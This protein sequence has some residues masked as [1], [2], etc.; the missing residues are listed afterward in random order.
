[1]SEIPTEIVLAIGGSVELSILAKATSILVLALV[2]LRMLRRVSASV[3]S[4]IL[5]STFGALMILPIAAV[6]LPPVALDVGAVSVRPEPPSLSAAVGSAPTRH[7]GTAA[8]N[9]FANSTVDRTRVPVRLLLI[10]GWVS[11]ALVFLVPAIETLGHLRRL[12]R[13]SRPWLNRDTLVRNL[14]REAGPSRHVELLV[15]DD[16]AVPFTYGLMRPAIMMPADAQDWTDAEVRRALVHELEHVRRRDWPVHVMARLVCAL[17]WFHPLV[18]IAWRRFCLE[19][20]RACDDAVVRSA[21]GIAY[22]EQLV[23]LARMVSKRGSAPVLSMA[24]RGDLKTRVAAVLDAKQTRGRVGALSG[25]LTAG[26]A[27]TLAI[28]ISPLKA[29]PAAGAGAVGQA[30]EQHDATVSFVQASVV[31]H[32]TGK[33][34]GIPP[35]ING[36][37]TAGGMTLKDLIRI[38]YGPSFPLLTSQIVG[39]PAWI[40]TDRFDIDAQVPSDMT[41]GASWHP[42]VKA[43]LQRLLGERFKLQL[44]R[45]TRESPS[46]D[47]VLANT[48]RQLGPGL[49]PSAADCVDLLTS[50]SPPLE[51]F[52]ERACG[53]NQ[54]APG[55]LAG[56]KLTMTQLA[57]VFS[58]LGKLNRVVRDRTG[59][60]GAFDVHLEYTPDSLAVSNASPAPATAPSPISPALLKALETQLGL[61]LE[62]TQG[63]VE[64]FVIRQAEK[65][66]GK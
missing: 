36:R 49:R 65:P 58:D 38:A 8:T 42:R 43:M 28:S 56:K 55:L 5:A 63:P 46:A 9:R 17:Y 32:T 59:L 35:L 64:V 40:D 31:P 14:S 16:L 10:A 45:E 50:P 27:V 19:S 2:A 54:N 29:T 34:P 62:P 44:S 57:G 47:L 39:G 22:A 66:T 6:S 30:P 33:P 60:E 23:A 18:W 15:H 3:R 25:G 7:P 1:M 61:R 48:D 37:F 21:E 52:V 26:L 11:G 51:H 20:E 41:F 13:S 53:L 4:V 24:N 12:R